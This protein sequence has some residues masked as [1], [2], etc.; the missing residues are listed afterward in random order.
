MQWWDE[1]KDPK[2]HEYMLIL[3]K[4]NHELKIAQLRIKQEEAKQKNGY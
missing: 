1:F 4:N 3:F 2:L